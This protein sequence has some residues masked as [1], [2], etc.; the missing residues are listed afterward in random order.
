MLDKEIQDISALILGQNDNFVLF[1]CLRNQPQALH[2]LFM[3]FSA[4]DQIHPRRL[5]AA[6]SQNICQLHDIP[7]GSVVH[8]R[9][10]V[11]QIV[12]EHLTRFHARR[13]AQRFHLRPNLFSA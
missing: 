2:T 6:V 3:L 9:E 4:G 8:A 13:R 1:C 7:A 12:R 11:P 5:N 10:Q